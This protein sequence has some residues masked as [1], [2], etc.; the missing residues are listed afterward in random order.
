MMM[1]D[2]QEGEGALLCKSFQ[3]SVGARFTT[4]PNGQNKVMAKPEIKE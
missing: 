4:I 2:A 3:A 1:L